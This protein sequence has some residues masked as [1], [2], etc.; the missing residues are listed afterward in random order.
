M[1][2][3]GRELERAMQAALAALDDEQR[4]ILVLRDLENLSY[5]EIGAVT[6]L[7][8]GTIKSR[9]HRARMAVK[10]HLQ[11]NGNPISDDRKRSRE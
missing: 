7:P 6:E 1:M 4:E 11:E 3:E 10:A 9:L 2:L 8:E 5:S